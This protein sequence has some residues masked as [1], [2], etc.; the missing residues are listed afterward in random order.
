MPPLDTKLR[1]DLE[2]VIV[3]ARDV[4]EKGSRN[5]LTGTLAVSEPKPHEHLSDEDKD[6]RR[7]L[8]ARA[9]QL[10]DHRDPRTDA[11]GIDHLVAE[12]AYEHWHRMLFAR[13]LVENDLLIHP[14]EEEAVNLEDCEELAKEEDARD[15]WELA[16]RYAARM[17]PQI[18][19]DAL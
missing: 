11:H 1:N 19:G 18:F 2:K 5:S 17:L 16:E 12:C 15:A 6:L 9:R 3:K 14:E 7:R 8:R 4:A 13:F 10:G